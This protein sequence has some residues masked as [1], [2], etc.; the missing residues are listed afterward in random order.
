V[1]LLLRFMYGRRRWVLALTT[2]AVLHGS[3]R[4]LRWTLV[5]FRAR[6]AGSRT[7]LPLLALALAFWLGGTVSSRLDRRCVYI[8]ARCGNR[9]CLVASRRGTVTP[10]R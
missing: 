6:A 1:M 3:P 8:C 10:R 4:P 9:V 7:R 2:G 5:G